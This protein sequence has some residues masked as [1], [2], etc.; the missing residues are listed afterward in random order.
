MKS[1]AIS[2]S[3]VI[4]LAGCSGRFGEAANENTATDS[5]NDPPL[6]VDGKSAARF[7][8][9]T[10]SGQPDGHPATRS[11]VSEGVIDSKSAQGAGHVLQRFGALL[12]QRDFADARTLWSD[13]GTASGL[14][15]TEFIAAYNKYAEIHSNVGAPGRPQ[16]AAGSI[17]IDVPFRLY[18]TLKD[19]KPFN[20]V[21]PITLRR[22]NEV[23]G[24]TEEQR[25]W[26]IAR[27]GLKSCP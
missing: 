25:R 16:G 22:I 11:P 21:G 5:S 19:G 26:H 10:K 6:P 18:G 9:I 13:G 23:D 27:S 20:L 15:E 17:Y 3:I 14:T 24:S 12:E 2:L 8:G 1:H 7:L 4:A